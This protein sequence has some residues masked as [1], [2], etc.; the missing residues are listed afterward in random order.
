[1]SGMGCPLDY[2]TTDLVT[3]L[4]IILWSC[5]LVNYRNLENKCDSFINTVNASKIVCV[6]IK[7]YLLIACVNFISHVIN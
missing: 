5:S 7:H 3:T 1:M 2:Y 4:N 6:F